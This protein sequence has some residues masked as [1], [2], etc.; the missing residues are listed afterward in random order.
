MVV[1]PKCENNRENEELKVNEIKLT[2]KLSVYEIP[3]TEAKFIEGLLRG[4]CKQA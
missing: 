3:V 4:M 1:S 2:D